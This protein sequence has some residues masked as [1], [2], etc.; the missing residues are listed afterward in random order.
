MNIQEY[1]PR[2]EC[3]VRVST[4]SG[5]SLNPGSNT[6]KS[7]SALSLAEPC[8]RQPLDCR[9]CPPPPPCAH[10]PTPRRLQQHLV[11]PVPHR[12]PRNPGQLH[13]RR[14]RPGQPLTV[15]S[16]GHLP[17]G[18]HLPRRSVIPAH[19]RGSLP[20]TPPRAL[21]LRAVQPSR[22]SPAPPAH[23]RAHPCSPSPHP[24]SHRPHPTPRRPSQRP[25]TPPHRAGPDRE[26]RCQQG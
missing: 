6:P 3:E 22:S 17:P 11:P 24:G 8:W 1:G 2:K 26:T 12:L 4:N 21:T 14:Q 7:L 18:Q 13:P 19:D 5:A 10:T 15:R 16:S 25:H 20:H 23:P 9:Q